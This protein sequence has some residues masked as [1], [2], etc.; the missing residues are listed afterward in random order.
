[1]DW[2]ATTETEWGHWEMREMD[3]ARR[4]K[5]RER[6]NQSLE[7]GRVREPIN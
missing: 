1:M 6:Q 7:G 5:E 2:Q 3:V 4:V